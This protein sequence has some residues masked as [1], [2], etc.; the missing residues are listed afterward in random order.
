MQRNN[1]TFEPGSGK[2]ATLSAQATGSLDER[3]AQIE[4]LLKPMQEVLGQYQSRLTDIE[5][6]RVESY[7]MLREQLGTLAETHRARTFR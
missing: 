3:K 5:K 1:E 6:S 7:S 2:F 4:L